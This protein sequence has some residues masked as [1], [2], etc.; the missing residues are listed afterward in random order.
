MTRRK[1]GPPA[2]FFFRRIDL[3]RLEQAL[4][5]IT[6]KKV[7]GK[8]ESIWHWLAA[9]AP[10]TGKSGFDVL[11]DLADQLKVSAKITDDVCFRFE[12]DG[13]FYY[14]RTPKDG[15]LVFFATRNKDPEESQS[16]DF[17]LDSCEVRVPINSVD[18]RRWKGL[19]EIALDFSE[20]PGEWTDLD[21]TFNGRGHGSI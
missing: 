4:R 21:A 8:P 11:G 12:V 13:T 7:S 1:A 19:L 17:D 16:S 5:G 20:A 6:I 2:L 10:D 15:G 9:V 14:F 3:S 18:E